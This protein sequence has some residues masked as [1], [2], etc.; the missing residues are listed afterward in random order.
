M[1]CL[2]GMGWR[3]CSAWADWI[4]ANLTLASN[5]GTIRPHKQASKHVSQRTSDLAGCYQHRRTLEFA[6][7]WDSV[8]AS[9]TEELPLVTVSLSFKALVE[10]AYP[11][12]NLLFAC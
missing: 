7:I 8:R 1:L 6:Q 11:H 5:K 3:A 10:L 4:Q 2:F 9:L 12:L